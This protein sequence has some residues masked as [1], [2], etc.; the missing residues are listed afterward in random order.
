MQ[1]IAVLG[2]GRMG[3]GIASCLLRAGYTVRVWN[4][5]R[6]KAETLLGSGALWAESPAIAVRGA[7]AVISMVADDDASS[8]VWFG[9][10]EGAFAGKSGGGLDA[11]TPGSF[12]IECSTLSAG[13]VARLYEKVASLG[14]RYIDCPVTGVP[15]MA[16]A[17]KL[18]LLTGADPVDLEQIRPVLDSF[19]VTTR[20]FG[21]VGAGT[22]YKL[23][24]NLM[25]AVQIAALAEGLALAE[26]LGLDRETVIA[27]IENSAAA[28]PQ[29]VRYT[30]K[31][32]ERNY[33]TDPAF[34]LGLRHK[35]AIY[36]V[37]LAK[38]VSSRV[39]LGEVAASLFAEA[40]GEDKTA[41]GQDEAAVIGRM[42]K[43]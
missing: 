41:S 31:M 35:D 22:A 28:S 18:T 14:L 15:E 42:A 11:M 21:P 12:V 1:T 19:S 40:I 13:H 27:A 34:T 30:R 8:A 38:D 17:G 20:H 32:A 39:A 3:Q 43:I 16:G 6:E 9:A 7:G 24:I 29:V 10:D 37:A 26:K 23:M 2:L 4:R 33:A 5:T 25:G 36:A